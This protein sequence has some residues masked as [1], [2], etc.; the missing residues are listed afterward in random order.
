MKNLAAIVVFLI[1]IAVMVK[2]GLDRYLGEV[3]RHNKFL[4]DRID[5]DG[6][7]YTVKTENPETEDD[8][9]EGSE[10]ETAADPPE[11]ETELVIVPSNGQPKD[12][13]TDGKEEPKYLT[14]TKVSEAAKI[15][16]QDWNFKSNQAFINDLKDKSQTEFTAE[17]IND[18]L[19]ND[20]RFE[21]G[22]SDKKSGLYQYYKK[23]GVKSS[24]DMSEKVLIQLYKYAKSAL[25]IAK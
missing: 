21:F 19:G 9:P 3:E 2:Y 20:I 1:V 10:T 5:R 23:K 8:P 4:E 25:K 15:I 14:I 22:L 7:Y 18:L 12:P 6:L 24:L 11:N 13:A 16:F 17:Y